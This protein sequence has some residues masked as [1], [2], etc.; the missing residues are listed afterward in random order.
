MEA[1]GKMTSAKLLK[2]WWPG[3]ELNHRKPFRAVFYGHNLPQ[4]KVTQSSEAT[5][6][7]AGVILREMPSKAS[8]LSWVWIANYRSFV[9]LRENGERENCGKYEPVTVN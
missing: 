3:T 7:S 9:E 8:V 2:T 1:A 6:G 4:W 5:P